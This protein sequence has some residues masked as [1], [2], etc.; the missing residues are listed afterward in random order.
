LLGR[1]VETGD[2]KSKAS[3]EGR[4]NCPH[5]GLGGSTKEEKEKKPY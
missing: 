4:K 2:K 3:S 5:N 1:V